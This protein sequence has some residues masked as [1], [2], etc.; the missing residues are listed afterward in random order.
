MMLVAPTMFHGYVIAQIMLYICSVVFVVGMF[1]IWPGALEG[2]TLTAIRT[3]VG[4]KVFKI[5]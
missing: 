1:K 2:E 4:R 3:Q 5:L